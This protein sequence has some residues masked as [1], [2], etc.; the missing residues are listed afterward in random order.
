MGV[1]NNVMSGHMDDTEGFGSQTVDLMRKLFACVH[2]RD[3]DL[4]YFIWLHHYLFGWFWSIF[5]PVS[6]SKTI[7][8]FYYDVWEIDVQRFY[9][10][11][12]IS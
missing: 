11:P 7:D 2:A 6:I 3:C 12:S 4:L 10:N 8:F 1:D 9:I 5:F